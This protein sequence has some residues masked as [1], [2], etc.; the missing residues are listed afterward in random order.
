MAHTLPHPDP[1]PPLPATLERDLRAAARACGRAVPA[2]AVRALAFVLKEGGGVPETHLGWIEARQQWARC[3]F[4]LQTSVPGWTSSVHGQ[5]SCVG[6]VWVGVAEGRWQLWQC[7]AGEGWRGASADQAP[8]PGEDAVGYLLLPDAESAGDADGSYWTWVAQLLRGRALPIL[9]ASLVVNLGMLVLPLFA[10][11][12]Y[13]KVVFNGVFETLWAL[14]IGVGLALAL[15]AAVRL[16]RARQVE[17]LTQ[18]LDEKVDHA[19]F[20]ALLQ[21]AARAGSQPGMAARFQTLYRDLAGARDFFSS[22]YLLAAADL[23]F[24]LLIWIVIGLIAWPLL[25]VILLWT[26]IYV[27]LGAYLKRQAKR[28]AQAATGAQLRKQALLTDAL[29]SLDLLRTSHAGARLFSRFMDLAREQSMHA[30]LHRDEGVRMAVLAQV[31]HAGTYAGILV[32]GAYLVYGQWISSGALVAVSMLGGRSLGTVSQALSTLG[33]WQELQDALHA[34]AP[35][36]GAKQQEQ[37]ALR[38]AA[39]VEGRILVRRLSHAYP[40]EPDC[41]RGLDFSIRAGERVAI[42][43][44]PGSGKSTLARVL[45]G[46]IRPTSGEVLVDDVH[47]LAHDADSRNSWLAFKPQEV[48]LV[49]GT[50]EDNILASVPAWITGEERAAALR[51]AV[52]AAGLDQ[53]LAAGSLSLDRR[54]EEYGANLS[55]GQRQK[56]ALARTLAPA[57][58]LLI[59]DEP[60]NGLDPDSE[61]LLAARLAALQDVTLVLVTHSAV[62][63]RACERVIALDRGQ[64]IADGPTREL[65]RPM[66]A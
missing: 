20:S 47:L 7:V 62:L 51:R 11:L 16:L 17:R 30:S 39:P 31:M 13:D 40:D 23:P 41:L 50:V 15:E 66:A 27:G 4:R 61:K 38:P 37:V 34:L 22:T 3:G 36:F 32:A 26:G 56:I 57:P 63:L 12:V 42:L 59:L 43:G 54:V 21:P 52:H 64:L 33:R 19:L 14:V 65:V 2:R 48:T 9:V 10:M 5:Q 29:S 25:V 1:L 28:S 45:A 58:R 53:D 60:G 35:F 46:A 24:V 44:R 8:H 49:A 6:A 18:V 55:G